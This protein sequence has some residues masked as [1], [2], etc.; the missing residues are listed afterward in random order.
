MITESE[1]VIISGVLRWEPE[2][3]TLNGLGDRCPHH[4]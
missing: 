2:E 4:G 3:G 1:T